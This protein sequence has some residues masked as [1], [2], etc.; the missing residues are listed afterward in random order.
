VYRGESDMT[1]PSAKVSEMP[2]NLSKNHIFHLLA[3]HRSFV[4]RV[5][6]HIPAKSGPGCV[7]CISKSVAQIKKNYLR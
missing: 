4:E 2:K 7:A 5:K 3:Q 6:G 1:Y